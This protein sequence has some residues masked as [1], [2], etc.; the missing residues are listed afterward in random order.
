MILRT[1]VEL[2]SWSSY[3]G[4]SSRG[5]L[6]KLTSGRQHQR[7]ARSSDDVKDAKLMS[8]QYPSTDLTIYAKRLAVQWWTACTRCMQPNNS[9][10]IDRPASLWTASRT[11]LYHRCIAFCAKASLQHRQVSSHSS[12]DKRMVNASTYGLASQLQRFIARLSAAQCYTLR[13]MQYL[14]W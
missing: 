1:L 2:S 7:R 6:V 13:N 12:D 10:R 5:K 3:A 14:H 8:K 11:V 9:L 4:A